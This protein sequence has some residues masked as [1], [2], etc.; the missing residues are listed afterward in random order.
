MEEDLIHS[1]H[2]PRPDFPEEKI[3]LGPLDLH[4]VE[5]SMQHLSLESRE[6]IFMRFHEGMTVNE[7]AKAMGVTGSAVKM[8]I[9]RGLIK[10]RELLL[11][12]PVYEK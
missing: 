10:L 3:V 2:N 12:E 9:H 4:W 8:R 11:G 7:I 1:A 6:A 5:E